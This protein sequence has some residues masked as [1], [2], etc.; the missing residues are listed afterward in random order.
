MRRAG[1]RDAYHGHGKSVRSGASR[2]GRVDRRARCG[3]PTARAKSALAGAHRAARRHPVAARPHAAPGA[4]TRRARRPRRTTTSPP[5]PP[6]PACCGPAATTGRDVRELQARLRQIAWLLRGADRDVRRTRPSG[7]SRASRASA[8]CRAPVR[9]TPSPGSGCCGM[10][11]EPGRWELYLMGGQPADPPDARCLTGRVLCI[12]K[13]S[14]TLSWMIDGKDG[15]DDGRA[16]RLAVHADPGGHVQRLLEVPRT[17]SRRSTTPPCRTRCSS[18]A[19]RPCTTR[20]TS[21]PRGYNGAS[22]GCVNVRDEEKIAALFAQVQER[23]QGRRLLVSAL[24]AMRIRGAGGTGGTCPA[25]AGARAERYGGNPG[26]VRRPMTSRLT[27][28]CAGAAENVTPAAKRLS[29]K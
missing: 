12:S 3:P 7:R 26:S 17:T 25:R 21:R 10:T 27:C 24:R 9:P 22:H 23:R 6:R 14:R 5:L 29:G 20:R 4:A 1:G 19:A 18:A 11:R 2:A 15:V 13:T 8:G 16:V 28:Y